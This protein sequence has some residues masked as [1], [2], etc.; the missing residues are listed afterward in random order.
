MVLDCSSLF[1]KAVSKLCIIGEL[2]NINFKFIINSIIY[3]V[4][5]GLL[6]IIIVNFNVNIIQSNWFLKLGIHKENNYLK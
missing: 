2:T 5:T 6:L 3:Q 4:T 1:E